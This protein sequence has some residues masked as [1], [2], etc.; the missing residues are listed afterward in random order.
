MTFSWQNLQRFPLK[1]FAVM[2]FL[3]Y[4]VV[5]GSGTPDRPRI[6]KHALFSPQSDKEKDN[7]PLIRRAECYPLSSFSMY[8]DFDSATFYNYL[9]DAEGRPIP[10]RV[11][12]EAF[13]STMLKKNYEN[14]K[15]RVKAQRKIEG[16]LADL[17]D[18]ARR[19]AGQSVMNDL[20]NTYRTYFEQNPSIRLTLHEVDVWITPESLTSNDPILTRDRI[21]YSEPPSQ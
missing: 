13:N 5:E 4:L 15:R 2:S 7:Q 10:A 21:A 20:R 6:I 8:A 16:K 1:T 3:S 12:S 9:A 17:P 14:S 19:E 18:E 11:I